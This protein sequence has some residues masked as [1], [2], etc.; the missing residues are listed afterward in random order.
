M[1]NLCIGQ[2]VYVCEIQEYG[3]RGGG[4]VRREGG[5]SGKEGPDDSLENSLSWERHFHKYPRKQKT[6]EAE[7]AARG[8]AKQ[9]KYC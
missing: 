6:R 1:L 9:K 3:E 7:R 2:W 8:A 4:G 5:R